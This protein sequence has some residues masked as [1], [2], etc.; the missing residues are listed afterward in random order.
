M[1]VLVVTN[2]YPTP[3]WPSYGIFVQEHVQALRKLGVDVDVFFT[4]PKRT[5]ATY[6]TELPALARKLRGGKYDV[7]HAQH[8]YCVFQLA[9][10]RPLIRSAAPVVFTNHEG[11]A[12]LPQGIRD[13]QA[14]FL[15]QFVYSK[16]LK[17]WALQLADYVV[18]V[19]HHLPQVVGYRRPYEVIA[20]GV[21]IELFRPM[22]RIPCRKM[23][24]LPE[25]GQIVLFPASPK[26]DF[27]KGFDLFQRSLTHLEHPVR[28][29]TGGSIPHDQM[30]LYMN[31]ADVV[32]QTS[33]FEA[34]PMIVKE[35][36]S[37]NCSVVSTDV[38]DVRDLF[39]GMPGYFICAPNP[40][41][42]ADKIQQALAFDQRLIQG[43]TRIRELGLSLEQAARKYLLI[44]ERLSR[45]EGKVYAHS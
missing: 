12:F 37:C 2:M 14:D 4:N 8:S 24:A 34:S 40:Q 18:P 26:R 22:D 39:K 42:V 30:P 45:L 31:A 29:V 10:V 41:D 9:L 23:L 17:R 33:R 25:D 19:E 36:M 43:R 11:E 27:N 21:N 1:K 28:A 35:A 20:P 3:E 16:R 38:G 44:Y 7:I 5:R 32:V 13:P 15:K 6:L